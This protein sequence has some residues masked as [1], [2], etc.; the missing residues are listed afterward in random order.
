MKFGCTA[1]SWDT[2]DGKHLL[3]RTYDQYG[4]LSGN[5]IASVPQGFAMHTA[6]EP[7]RGKTV[8]VQHR[9]VG[10]AVQGLPVPVMVDGIN[11]AGLMGALLHY[12]GFAHY[13]TAAGAGQLDV[14]PAYLTAYLLG[15]CRTVDEVC[16]QMEQINLTAEPIF[17][18]EMPVHYIFSDETGEAVLIEPDADGQRVYRRTLGVLANS[19]EY[20]WHRTNLRNYVA[21]DNLYKPPRDLLGEQLVSLGEGHGG[22]FGLPGDYS[23]PSR[24]VRMAFVKHYAVKGADEIDGVGRMMHAFAAVDLPDGIQKAHP[25]YEAYEQTLCTSAMCAESRTYYFATPSNRRIRA[26]CVERERQ[27]DLCY[28]DLREQQDIDYMN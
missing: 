7:T 20:S 6:A 1:F 16:A 14:H 2:R 4:D 13:D 26:L 28:Y 19:P 5:R 3:G 27:T 21:V 11:D 15:Q 22:G 25:D 10:M 23:S 17:G 8:T 18:K 9:F 12:P 24:F